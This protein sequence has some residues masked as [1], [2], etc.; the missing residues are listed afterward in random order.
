MGSLGN[1]GKLQLACYDHKPQGYQGNSPEA[2]SAAESGLQAL[3]AAQTR[4]NSTDLQKLAGIA[5]LASHVDSL[6]SPLPYKIRSSDSLCET[7]GLPGSEAEQLGASRDDQFAG[8]AAPADLAR[9]PP[10]PAKKVSQEPDCKPSSQAAASS[11]STEM[12]Q[13]LNTKDASCEAGLSFID[14]EQRKQHRRTANRES[15]R[16]TRERRLHACSRLEAEVA[17]AAR[18]NTELRNRL[19]TAEAEQQLG[20]ELLCIFLERLTALRRSNSDVAA[21]IT[22]KQKCQQQ[23]SQSQ[24]MQNQAGQQTGSSGV[25]DSK[26]SYGVQLGSPSAADR[27]QPSYMSASQQHLCSR[28]ND[29]PQ[30]TQAPH[31]SATSLQNAFPMAGFE[32]LPSHDTSPAAAAARLGLGNLDSSAAMPASRQAAAKPAQ[33]AFA[34]DASAC[35]AATLAAV[36]SEESAATMLRNSSLTLSGG[37]SA[38]LELLYNSDNNNNT[39]NSNADDFLHDPR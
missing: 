15:A 26:H 8:P 38:M 5:H 30:T 34:S 39:S 22:S 25:R 4:R 32:L 20:S 17:E 10:K 35:T 19:A 27:C 12:L 36:N 3:D 31:L 14:A 21:Q 1:T 18:S 23:Q 33:S 9:W 37:L 24:M 16:K 29:W 6:S 2:G 11:Q 7:T 13:H 28:P